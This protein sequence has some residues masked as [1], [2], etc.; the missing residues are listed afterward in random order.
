MISLCRTDGARKDILELIP[1]SPGKSRAA[2]DMYTTFPWEALC[3][4]I[5]KL[6]VQRQARGQV[7]QLA[8]SGGSANPSETGESGENL[9]TRFA[10]REQNPLQQQGVTE[11]R[12]RESKRVKQR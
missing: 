4:E 7:L 10:T 3:A 6:N 5:R 9:A 1:H 8:A 12:R 11:W 2:I